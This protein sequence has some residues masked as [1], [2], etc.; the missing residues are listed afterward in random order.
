MT[1]SCPAP[2]RGQITWGATGRAAGFRTLG[3]SS[4]LAAGGGQLVAAG[5][6]A[7]RDGVLLSSAVPRDDELIQPER[8]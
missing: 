2:T 3:G 6:L 1:K 4:P 8:R 5:A 7:G